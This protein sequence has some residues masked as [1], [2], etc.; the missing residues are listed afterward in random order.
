MGLFGP[1]STLPA[2]KGRDM[3]PYQL[4]WPIC[5]V[6]SKASL[7]SFSQISQCIQTFLGT[8][9][10]VYALYLGA[11]AYNLGVYAHIQE[12]IHNIQEFMLTYLGVYAT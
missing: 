1:N 6:C 5:T 12:F 9:L 11:Y 7:F 4:A 2:G 10:G 8:H 3:E